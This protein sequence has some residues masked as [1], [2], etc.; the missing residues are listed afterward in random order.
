MTIR[1]RIEQAIRDADTPEEAAMEVCIMLEDVI[2]LSG[3]GW[4]D[5]DPELLDRLRG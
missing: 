3:N 2:D 1:E 5:D 4:F